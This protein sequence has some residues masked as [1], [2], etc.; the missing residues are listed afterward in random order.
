MKRRQFLTNAAGAAAAVILQPRWAHGL[1]SNAGEA[2]GQDLSTVWPSAAQ[3]FRKSLMSGPGFSFLYDGKPADPTSVL[4]SG[5]SDATFSYASGVEV[6]RKAVKLQGAN[7]VEYTLRIRNTGQGRSAVIQNV[8]ALDVDFAADAIQGSYVV[9]SG[10]GGYD[11]TYP[12]E[13]FAIRKHFFDPTLPSDAVV[14]LTTEG[15]RSSNRDLPFYFVH[16]D[17]AQAGIFVAIGWTGQWISTISANYSPDAKS[18][19][20]LHL[21]G[22][23]PGLQIA[24]EPGEEIPGPRILIGSYEGTVAD[25]SNALRKLIRTQYTPKLNGN[26]MG[27]IA[28]YDAWWNIV[29]NYDEALM[30]PVAAA[31]ASLGQEYFLLD[32]AW[33][34]GSNGPE[35]FSG[36]VG[37]WKHVDARKFPKGLGHF[38]D[39]VR[40]QNLR[41]GLWF[42]PERVHRSSALAKEHKDWVIWMEG[43]DYGLLY[44]GHPNVR[45]WVREM[46][47][48]YITQLGIEYIRHDF[49]IDPLAYWNSFDTANRHGMAQ[50]KHIE[51]FYQVIDWIRE[52]HPKTV[53][54]CCASGGRRIDLE[55][56]RRFHTY[57]ISDDTVDPEVDRFHLEGI[58]YFLPGNYSYVQYTLPAPAQK[59]FKPRDIDYLDLFGGAMGLGGRVDQ[60]PDAQKERFRTLEKVHKQLRPFLME[61]YYPLLPQ[62]LDLLGWSGWQFHN[63]KTGSGFVQAF[64]QKSTEETKHLS[65]RGLAKD[66]TYN[67]HDPLGDAQRKMS[68]AEAMKGVGF[69]LAT[70][71]SQILAYEPA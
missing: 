53:L 44:Y 45:I 57:W 9:S 12:P 62:P 24:L 51:G 3:L 23:I 54:E 38:A 30:Q 42:E 71:E 46:M 66:R 34:E 31:A 4:S 60:W 20:A 8:N 39:Y 18:P 13:A 19:S 61:D 25:G 50:I 56:A 29:E 2:G 67:F 40:S 68:G 32:A 65:L 26:E 1:S 7:A 6:I 27:V 48:A 15:G 17:E 58:N 49:N 43:S 10:G 33:Y 41:F 59:D 70:M 14:T 52:R 16:N 28:T 21:R 69:T 22:G 35:G 64:R 63:P 55:T 11:G 36:G 5:Q 47:D 37:N